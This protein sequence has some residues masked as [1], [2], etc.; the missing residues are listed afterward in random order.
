MSRAAMRTP[1]SGVSWVSFRWL[2]ATVPGK[3][4]ARA[5]VAIP[6]TLGERFPGV[7]YLQFDTGSEFNFLHGGAINDVASSLATTPGKPIRI[8][9]TIAG[10]SV[11]D[12]PFHVMADY[13]SSF[14]D[15]VQPVIGTLGLPFIRHRRVIVDFPRGRL[16]VLPTDGRLP[17]ELEQTADFL[18]IEDRNGKIYVPLQFLGT[19]QDGFFLDTGSSAFA[20]IT[21]SSE[22]R[23]MTRRD[24]DDPRNERLQVPSW[25]QSVDLIGAPLLGELRFGP[26]V[27]H[28]PSVY[29]V[30]DGPFSFDRLPRTRGLIGNALFWAAFMLV[31]DLPRGRVGIVRSAALRD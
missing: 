13:R 22:W 11:T 31:L 15:G 9:G 16:A 24:V 4:L 6:A 12:E 25:D 7:H 23:H 5:G 26:V 19:R 20:V 30:A 21:S 18:S 10:V 28:A 17:R 29:A 8:S 2:S 1:R 14:N 3:E 27:A